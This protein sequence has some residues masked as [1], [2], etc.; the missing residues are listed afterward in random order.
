MIVCVCA[1]VN[2]TSLVKEIK[3]GK[4]FEDVQKSLDVCNNC[5]CCDK[6]IRELFDQYSPVD[7]P[8]SVPV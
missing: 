6:A 7:K 4:T 2:N 1:N 5:C 3:D 8:L